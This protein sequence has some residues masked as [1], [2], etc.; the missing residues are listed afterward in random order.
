MN[1]WALESFAKMIPILKGSLHPMLLSITVAVADNLN[2]KNSGISAAA[3]IA[4]DAMVQ[5]LGE[6]QG[7]RL[8]QPPAAEW[9]TAL[10]SLQT[11]VALE[12][13][14]GRTGT[15]GLQQLWLAGFS[16][17]RPPMHPDHLEVDVR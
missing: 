6:L 5:N 12:A 16:T 3:A 2:S 17:A 9:P 1:Q 10:S 8:P 14:L 15:L 13:S 7:S 11:N 4:L